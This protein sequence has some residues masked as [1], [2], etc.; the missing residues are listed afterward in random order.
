M[1]YDIINTV[2]P[3]WKQEKRIGGGSFGDVYKVVH[4]D[5]GIEISAAVKVISIPRDEEELQAWRANGNFTAG[6]TIPYLQGMVDDFTKEIKIM[7]SLKGSPHI[8]NVEDYKII[9]KKERK[10]FDIYIRME[11]LMPLLTYLSGKTLSEKEVIQLGCDICSALHICSKA[12]VIHR[13]VKPENIFFHENAGF[14]LGDFGIARSL[15]NASSG[16]S[17][18][19]TYSYMA[20]EVYHE[21]NYDETV[22][23]YSL[24]IVLYWLMNNKRHPFVD[25]HKQLLGPNEQRDAFY[26]RVSGMPLPPPCNASPAF[27]EVILRACD[28]DPRKRFASAS[29]MKHALENIEIVS[30][31]PSEKSGENKIERGS[32]EK[33]SENSVAPNEEQG[34][35]IDINNEF[36]KTRI[37]PLKVGTFNNEEKGGSNSAN[38]FMKIIKKGGLIIAVAAVVA[39]V[40]FAIRIRSGTTPA[41]ES[42]PAPVPTVTQTQTETTETA[43]TTVPKTTSAEANELPPLPP[44]EFY[45]YN[46][47]TYGFYDAERYGFQTYDEVSDFCH[48]QNGHLAVINNQAEN[49][50]L[51]NLMKDNYTI[52]AFFGYTDKDEEGVWVWDGDESDFE[53][54]TKAG[55]WELPD[56]GERWGGGE[57]KDGGEDY[58]EFNYDKDKNW[59][60]PND[61][62]WNDAAFMENTT[63]FFCEWEYDMRDVLGKQGN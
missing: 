30:D 32:N 13:D 9:E 56:N 48:Q 57:W 54:W 63:I 17:H 42:E 49:Y 11:L 31:Q 51:Y 27:R 6:N 3:E 34:G 24:G 18:K 28:P 36:S 58:A 46:G 23:T 16:L 19:G 61:T 38:R 60:A 4:S 25:P 33:D 41:P 2:W 35:T 43:D 29:E 37:V 12:K 20:P 52:T 5:N 15:E 44:E 8:V 7:I 47:H 39:G 1:D 50:Y 45:Y 55:E 59:G 22:D 62:S 14:K 40:A 53:N 21:Q 26:K 10:G